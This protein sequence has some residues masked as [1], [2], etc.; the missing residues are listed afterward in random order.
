MQG[1]HAAF[2]EMEHALN[3]FGLDKY[4]ALLWIARTMSL[5]L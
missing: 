4:N 5:A 1:L 2:G 3:N